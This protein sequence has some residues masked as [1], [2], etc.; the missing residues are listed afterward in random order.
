MS[1]LGRLLGR[2][3]RPSDDGSTEKYHTALALTEEVTDKFRERAASPDPF[4]AL[5]ADL[6]LQH[7]DIGLL[8]E[9]YE[10]SQEA[11]IFHGPPDHE[12]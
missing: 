9:V 4:R 6:F 7:H 5:M 2:E 12:G 1:L 8:T 3:D 11:K 10:A